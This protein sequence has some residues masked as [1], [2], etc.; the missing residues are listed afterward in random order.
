MD[1]TLFLPRDEAP[2]WRHVC[3]HGCLIR[4]ARHSGKTSFAFQAAVSTVRDGSRVMVLC[5]EHVLYSKMPRP[6]TPLGDLD[7]AALLRMEFL[8]VDS[9]ADTLREVA[10]WSTPDEAPALVLIDDDSFTDAGEV[11]QTA[12]TLSALENVHAWL[13]R[14]GRCFH[15]V[16]VSNSFPERGQG[17][18]LPFAA[19][20]LVCF[21]FGSA[22]TV[23]VQTLEGD[24][25]E[26]KSLRLAWHDGLVLEK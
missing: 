3:G 10:A 7:E 25:S 9:L 19:F 1:V 21:L 6:F 12:Q 23:S 20:P 18:E 17:V 2:P 14:C 22:G 24:I 5:Q 11:C 15:Y 26:A 4:G 16:F 13:T 8:Y